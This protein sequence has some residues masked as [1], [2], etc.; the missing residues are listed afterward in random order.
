[1]LCVLYCKGV[2]LNMVDNKGA[3]FVIACL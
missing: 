1:M 2:E 3:I